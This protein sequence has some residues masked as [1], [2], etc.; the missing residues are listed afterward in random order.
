M[1][2]RIYKY[3]KYILDEA[4]APRA[5]RTKSLRISIYYIHDHA[6]A[7]LWQ[8]QNNTLEDFFERLG[9]FKLHIP[10]VNNKYPEYFKDNTFEFEYTSFQLALGREP[11]NSLLRLAVIGLDIY[12]ISGRILHSLANARTPSA[13]ELMELKKAC[14]LLSEDDINAYFYADRVMRAA[15]ANV[16]IHSTEMESI[17]TKP[18]QK[19]H[20]NESVKADYVNIFIVALHKISSN[21]SVSY[22]DIVKF[23]NI[24]YPRRKPYQGKR[25]FI[26]FENDSCFVKKRVRIMTCIHSATT[27]Q[28]RITTRSPEKFTKPGFVKNDSR[29]LHLC[30][31][32]GTNGDFNAKHIH[33]A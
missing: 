3:A 8:E 15:L 33:Q 21:Q 27:E 17:A 9:R 23:L 29:H 13:S 12:C 22:V 1:I 5:W 31:Y 18:L 25:I 11:A 2:P 28:F 24:L 32:A 19:A 10:S 30:C 26:Y 7:M 16:P 6:H 4:L 20:P 14:L